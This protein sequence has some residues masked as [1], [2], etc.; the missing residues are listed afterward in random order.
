MSSSR[1][2]AIG[3]GGALDKAEHPHV[4]H[5]SHLKSSGSLTILRD[6]FTNTEDTVI[7]NALL[8]D[9]DPGLGQATVEKRH[10]DDEE[11][12][13]RRDAWTKTRGSGVATRRVAG[14][15]R[16]SQAEREQTDG[17]DTL[18]SAQPEQVSS[19]HGG[20]EQPPDDGDR[21]AQRMLVRPDVR[22][23]LRDESY[24]GLG[25]GSKNGGR[26]PV[27]RT[28]VGESARTLPKNCTYSRRTEHDGYRNRFKHSVGSLTHDPSMS[29]LF[30]AA[31]LSDEEDIDAV[32]LKKDAVRHSM[33]GFVKGGKQ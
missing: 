26:S 24:E 21:P 12:P 5:P 33:E 32:T 27:G 7:A 31:L 14:S 1:P 17:S 9:V 16:T 2:R 8:G 4:Y 23:H 29:G 19:F 11:R 25:S 22:S 6:P 20:P 18:D 13:A 3:P 30:G 10:L 28:M 15:S